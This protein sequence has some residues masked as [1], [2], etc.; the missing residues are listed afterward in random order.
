MF[1]VIREI[2]S[3]WIIG[4]NVP[5]IIG[6]ELE[7]ICLALESEGY[8]VQPFI[9][10]SAS[11]GA[12]DKRDRI[13]IIAHNNKF[14]CNN[15]QKGQIKT[16]QNEIRNSK[17]EK[18]GGGKQQ[19][20]TGQSDIII[21]IGKGLQRYSRNDLPGRETEQERSSEQ[22][23]WSRP[24]IEVA[25]ELCGSNARVS[26]ELDETMKLYENGNANYQETIAKIDL[27]RGEIMRDVWGEKHKIKQ[28]SFKARPKCYND[29]MHAMPYQYTHERWKLGQRIEKDKILCDLW[30]RIL[31][32]PFEKTQNLQ[33]KM[34]E[35]I[36]AIER[37]EKTG[38]DR[39]NRIKG[40]G[41]SVNPYVAYQI[42][43]AIEETNNK[44]NENKI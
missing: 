32:M 37:N 40:L 12:W 1:R 30:N 18:Q 14:G 39:T 38:H 33:F 28:T 22:T 20:G 6:M 11:I 26:T 36:R 42:F 27:F 25:S 23:N 17:I 43:K 31:S 44:L 24:W 34:F 41:N 8:E 19:C 29:I 15:E 5:G 16:I 7:N 9:I 10:P 3:S 4:E 35:R 13:W 21:T 2:Q